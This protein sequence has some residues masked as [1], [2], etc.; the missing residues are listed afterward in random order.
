MLTLVRHGRTALNSEGRYQGHVDPPLST[1]GEDE[2]RSLAALLRSAVDPAPGQDDA[3]GRRASTIYTSDLQRASRTAALAL[4][5]ARV[6]AEPRLR[7]LDFGAFDGRTYKENLAEFGDA[8]RAWIDDPV[9][10]RPPGG[11]VLGELE[12]R[13]LV[14]LDALPRDGHIVAFTHGGPI[15]VLLAR[16]RGVRFQAVRGVRIAPGEAIRILVPACH[17]EH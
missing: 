13:V 4:P 17:H 9:R 7:E 8:F 2:A 11:E 5:G 16:L 14:W 6:I 10:V 1:G 12:A 15:R 3:S